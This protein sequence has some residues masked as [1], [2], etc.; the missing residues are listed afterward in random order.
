M[1]GLVT[2][3][4]WLWAIMLVTAPIACVYGLIE[5]PTT[6][7]RRRSSGLAILGLLLSALLI[8]GLATT[9]LV[10]LAAAVLP[11]PLIFAVAVFRPSILIP[12]APRIYLIC[13]MAAAELVWIWAMWDQ[14]VRVRP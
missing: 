6:P 9:V 5:A 1:P 11:A 7:I 10:P 4:A 3:Y 8:L 14:F 12:K 13:C 2:T